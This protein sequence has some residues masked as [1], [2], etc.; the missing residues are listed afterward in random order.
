MFRGVTEDL[1][2]LPFFERGERI[3]LQECVYLLPD[4]LDLLASA[5]PGEDLGVREYRAGRRDL[6]RPL[7]LERCRAEIAEGDVE[8]RRRRA[9]EATRPGSA[10][11]VHHEVE[12][13]PGRAHPDRLGVLTTHVHDCPSVREH[14]DGPAP[15]AGDL[16][17]L[18]VAEGD[19]VAPVAGA[20]DE[21]DPLFF[22]VDVPVANRRLVGV[23]GGEG[24]A[25]PCVDQ[26]PADDLQ[27]VV[28][29]DRLGLRRTDV[30][31]SR[32]CHLSALPSA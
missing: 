22:L 26:R 32:V 1:G 17:R 4:V 3:A 5:E 24:D 28:D 11:V 13:L 30:D 18:G 15:V 23:L 6:H 12:D 21:A 8:R 14:V 7:R 31:S 16:G 10:L 29:D 20:D 25:R 19:L 27:V 2:Q 9:E